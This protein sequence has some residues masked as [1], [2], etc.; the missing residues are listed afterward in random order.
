MAYATITDVKLYLGIDT[1]S[2]NEILSELVLDAQAMI[3]SYCGQS[4]EATGDTL[5]RFDTRDVIK[6]RLYLDGPLASVTSVVIDAD[7][8]A[9]VTLTSGEYVLYPRNGTPYHSLSILSSSTNYWEFTD[10]PENGIE[11]TGRWAYSTAAPRDI[12]RACIRLTAFLYRQRD[13]QVFETTAIPEAGI[14]TT[15]QGFPKDVERMLKPYKRLM[16]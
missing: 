7:G 1:D 3:D 8:A 12:R 14:I 13:S 11:I 10:D 6:G 5:R 9:P 4:F 2:D 16:V 15:P